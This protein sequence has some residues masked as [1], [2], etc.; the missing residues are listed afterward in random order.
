MFGNHVDWTCD[1]PKLE[2]SADH[3]FGTLIAQVQACQ[4]AG[5]IRA[6]EPILAAL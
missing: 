6:G 3:C 4:A 1:H 5:L 2:E